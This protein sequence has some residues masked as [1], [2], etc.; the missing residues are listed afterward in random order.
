MA[1]TTDKNIADALLAV[2]AVQRND[3]NQCAAALELD[4]PRGT[5]QHRLRIAERLSPKD[6]KRDAV[7][8]QT[9]IR[10][11]EGQVRSL[12]K[13]LERAQQ[14]RLEEQEIERKIFGLART[15]IE[16]P[17]WI[18]KQRRG[19]SGS[20]VPSVIW[21][22]EHFGETVKPEEVNGVN[23]YNLAIA[24]R[25]VRRRVER[26]IDLAKNHMTAADYPGIVVNA[27]G[28]HVSGEIHAELERTNEEDPYPVIEWAVS[29]MVWGLNAFA[30]AFGKVYYVGVPGNHGRM[31]R[32]PQT[33]GRATRNADWLIHRMVRMNLKDDKRFSWNIP[34]SGDAHYRVFGHR[35]FA[36]HGDALGTKGG[37]GI[38]GAIGPIMRGEIKTAN[39][40]SQ[41]GRAYDTLVAGH[42]H[43]MLWLLRAIINN[44]LKGYDPFARFALRAP[45]STPSQAL[46][47]THAKWGITAKWEVF[48]D[49]APRD[50][51]EPW[52]SAYQEAA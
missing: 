51:K 39:S 31:D 6:K 12:Q 45:S 17:D 4:I 52:V 26:T 22:D 35:Y 11:L 49:G 13:D 14:S 10:V 44:S 48:V 23:E 9:K 18:V 36:T 40:E 32:K 30:D 33:R 1:K 2:E 15:Q 47:F 3:G 19:K 20:G 43:Q 8:T 37:D 50:G 29:R 25:R 24:D 16:P 38:I 42:W 34:I 28:D 7:E 5:L 41:I 27:L 46:W 21:S